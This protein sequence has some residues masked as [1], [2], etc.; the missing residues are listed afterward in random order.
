MIIYYVVNQLRRLLSSY[1]QY[2]INSKEEHF[3]IIFAC[4]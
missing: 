1:N 2:Q 3:I 4:K